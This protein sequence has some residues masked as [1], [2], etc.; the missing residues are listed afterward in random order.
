[1]IPFYKSL[2][3]WQSFAVIAAV[4]AYQAGWVDA[5]DAGKILAAVLAILNLFNV[6]PELRARK[7]V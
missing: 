6:V 3:F 7:L 5:P 4:I 1:M 2:K